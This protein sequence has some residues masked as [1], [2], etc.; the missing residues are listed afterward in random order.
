MMEA[1]PVASILLVD[2]HAPNLLALEAA[3]EPLGQR[4]VK[5]RS[6]A[7]ALRKLVDEDFAVIL[8]DVQMPELDGYQTARLIKA[9]ERTR[10][11]PLLFLTAIHR[12]EQQALRGYAQGAVDYLL[13]PFDPD[14]LRAKVTT[15]VDLYRRGEQL[16][17]R[18]ARLRQQE[19]ELLVRRG[20]AHARA[21]LD[22]MPQA[23]WAA[24][25]DGSQAWCNPAWTA[26]RGGQG[27]GEPD[28]SFLDVVHPEER[29][30]VRTGWSEALRS[31]RMWE[32]QHRLGRADSWRWHIVRVT[33]LP[34][35]DES[36]SGFLCTAT[37]ID[38]ERRTQ[39]VSQILS[40]A[41]VVLS[42]S[43]DYHATLARL[44]QLAVPRFA[45]WCAVDVVEPSR[46]G[47]GPSRVAVAHV[48]S[49]KAERVLELHQRYPPHEDDVSGV[50]RVL[51]SEVPE[52][53]PEV[54]DTLL[55]RIVRDSEHLALLREVGFQSCIRVPMR[56]RERNFGVITFA[57][58][59]KRHR[60]DRRDLALAEELGRRAAVAVDNALLYQEA[61]RAQAEAQEANRLKD[62]FLAT[63]SH[64]LRTPL[65]SILGWTQMLLKR[66]EL[67]AAGRRRGLETIERN[68]RVQRQ[69]VEDLLDV[70]R[71]TSGKLVLDLK[72]VP[73]R[74][75][76]D[77]ALESVRPTAEARGV[78]LEAKVDKLSESVLADATRLQQV[79]WNLLTNAIK[80]TER[81]GRVWLEAYR[82]ESTVALTVRDTG[83]GIAREFLPHVFERFRQGESGREHGGL[84]LG[85]A[86]VRHL[87]ELHGGT[88]GVHSDGP[89]TGATFKV[90][91]PLRSER[92]EAVTSEAAAPGTSSSGG[93]KH[94]A[95]EN[96]AAAVSM[97][98][99]APAV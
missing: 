44:A 33:P 20:E 91:L 23:V 79:L 96:L 61:Q 57:I 75:V 9:Q 15:F 67:D 37:D 92:D 54:P 98:L 62:D 36:W 41:S 32:G 49:G 88:V 80:F 82:E 50:A 94:L 56:A 85:L 16:R 31:G 14:V 60:Y 81:G 95:S 19:R 21:L 6:G 39:Q 12:D 86:I 18:E 22:A 53:L 77:A 13:K 51:A 71:I 63:L 24:R 72:E 43:L 90:R 40:H 8:L 87:V 11:I 30:V 42:S 47:G 97:R 58:A 28:S 89:G 45:D 73:L 68:A 69:L 99:S 83:R 25:T 52:L 59:G 26:L 78:Q 34:P 4:L 74:E 2:D 5:A 64:E 55:R 29:E 65:T 35:G 93:D 1:P 10:H 70:S 7:E 66:E 38:D 3:L 84:G 46:P 48:E 27:P 76:A 17:A